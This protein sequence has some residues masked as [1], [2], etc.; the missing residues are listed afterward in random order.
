[1]TA[2][3]RVDGVD[4]SHYQRAAIG[5]AAAKKAGVKWMYHKATEGGTYKDPKYAARRAEA[6][7]VGM[8]FGAYHFARASTRA[9]DAV[10]EAKHFLAYAKP[11][12][13]DL[14][15]ALDLETTEGLS[16]A[17]L[18]T[19]A[20]A[21]IGEVKR[22]TGVLPVVYTP[23]DLGTADDGCVI[24]RPRYNDSNRPPAR[25]WDI[26]QFSNGVLGVPD[27]VTGFGHVD[28][29][30]MRAGLRLSDL[31]IPV[32]P[33]APK[34]M[35]RKV[36]KLKF[37][38]CSMQ[39]NDTDQQHASDINTL[40]GR[41]YD[42]I[43]GTEAGKGAG[44][45]N[46]ELRRAAEKYGYVISLHR[47]YGTWVAVKK[48]IVAKDARFSVRHAL[49]GTA[50]YGAKGVVFAEWDMGPTFGK[51]AVASVHYVTRAGA[52]TVTRKAQLD[53][54]YA[55]AIEGWVKALPD[56]FSAFV[57]GDFNLR[58]Q[59][60]DWFKGQIPMATCWDDL[61]LWPNTGHGNIDGVARHKA[62]A[63]V[64]F[65]G[66]RVLDDGDLFLNTDHFVVE[67]DVEVRA[68]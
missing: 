65:T 38:H 68:V 11:V 3:M 12:P 15:P 1:M 9:G 21:F 19:W 13:G 45:M 10:A 67:V 31:L 5:Y 7:K 48:T 40:F 54:K 50:K 62:D 51:F 43:T 55:N 4:I 56:E 27:R 47:N 26:W 14:R 61:K 58:D 24:W 37:A 39:Y 28:L 18:R 46:V 2:P 34:P 53:L 30:V 8:P 64:R 57:A 32:K 25:K 42:V 52:G 33:A 36:A 63:R 49:D 59:P 16:L 41:K 44:N 23:F 17:Q 29:N 20:K 22:Q 35:V 60:N 66:A 6:K